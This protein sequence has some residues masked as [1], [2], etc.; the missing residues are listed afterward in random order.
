MHLS[1]VDSPKRGE[2]LLAFVLI[3]IAMLGGS[4]SRATASEAKEVPRFETN[5]L[6][7]FQG[8]CLICH[9]EN[10]QRNGLDLRT[11]DSVLKGGESGAAIVPGSAE[12]SLVLKKVSSGAMPM[13]GEKLKDE[14]IEA[15]RRWINAGALKEGEDPAVAGK[16]RTADEVTER[17]VMVSILRL[18]C[19]M[20]HGRRKQEG[21]LDLRTRAALLKGGKSGPAILPGKPEESFLIQ[22]IVAEEMHPP[23]PKLLE[24]YLVRSATSGELEKLRQW[25]AAGAPAKDE[26]PKVGG[27]PDPLVSEEQRKFWSF[28]SPKRPRVPRVR[29]QELVR[30]PIDAFLLEKLA[31]K[32]LSFSPEADRLVLLR[33]AYFDLIGLPPTP[34]EVQEYVKDDSL[35]AYERMIDRLLASPH[36]GERW[37]KYWLDAAG[38]ADTE[39]H[40]D[41]NPVRPHAYRY[42]DYVIRS[43][44]SDKPYDRFLLEQIAGDEL[45]DYKSA[46][47]PTPEQLDYLVATGFLRMGPD[48]TS[49]HL[50]QEIFGERFGVIADQVEI[51]SSAVMGLTMACARCHTHK[52]DPIPLRD[53]YRL[54]AILQAAYDPYDWIDPTIEGRGGEK[55]PYKQMLRYLPYT[56]E[57]ERREVETHNAP[58]QEEIKRLERSLEEK[59]RPLRKK[60]FAEELEKIPEGVREDVRKALET[61]AEKRSAL[62]KYLAKKFEAVLKVEQKELEEKF[63]DF[64]E[65]AGKLNKAIQEAKQKLRPEPNIRALFDMGGEPTPVYM[66]KRGDYRNPGP[67]VEPEVPSALGNGL[68]PYKIVKPAWDTSGR[69]LA[70]ARWLIQPNHPLTARVI[71]NRIWQNHFGKGLVA[72]PGNFGKTGAAPSHPELLDWLATE[73]VRQGW[74]LKSMHRLIMTSAAYRQ[75][76]RFDAS[77]HGADPDNLLLSRYRMRRMDAETVRDS[78]LKVAGRLDTTQFGPA[79]EPEVKP[80]GEVVSECLPGG[81]RRSIYMRQPRPKWSGK[82]APLTV[83]ETFDVQPLQPNSLQR[84]HSTVSS[85]ALQLMNSEVVRENSRYFAGRVTDAVG[86]DLEKQIERAY[87]VALSR[88]PSDEEREQ[89]VQALRDLTLYWLEHLEEEVPAEPKAG[90]ARWLAL[91]TLCHTILN[92]PGFVYVD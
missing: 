29:N 48:G 54:S 59:A 14:E 92:S 84:A 60:L 89:G 2:V 73:F 22:R 63:E 33:R 46:K 17:E 53:Y 61:P 5:I 7:I 24:A 58:I 28:Q 31:A 65:E 3:T 91:A 8:N 52:Y 81:C 72:T 78:I 74:S 30:T 55:D 6:P 76:S 70:L 88:W 35:S 34:E 90:K 62:E 23:D 36:Y 32:G 41:L 9:G 43:L 12:E 1:P 44:N 85:Q 39:G 83:L 80:D 16:R 37:G 75:G 20:C 64:K 15:I 45:F 77:R 21:G 69:R 11:R 13:G 79:V 86:A 82:K 56:D 42:R 87:L 47:Q 26:V 51:L 67:L 27:G 66:L 18:K 50:A 19:V 25:I 71:V 10:L 38:Y 49:V 4:V 57:R 40:S 68:A